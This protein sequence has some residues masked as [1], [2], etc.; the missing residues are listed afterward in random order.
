M[1]SAAALGADRAGIANIDA[2]IL[3]LQ[4]SIEALRMERKT[5]QTRL[6]S[7]T[8][9]V[10]TLP[11]EIVS[12]IFIQFLPVYPLCPRM[13]GLLSPICL[14]QICLEWRELALGTPALWRAVSTHALTHERQLHM[15][16][17]WLS[18]SGCCPLSIKMEGGIYNADSCHQIFA[19]I[20]P[21]CARWEYLKL[22]CTSLSDLLT[23]AGPIPLLRDLDIAVYE[24][25]LVPAAAF[26]QAPRLRAFTDRRQY[27][28]TYPPNFLPWDQLT[29]VT[30]V[31]IKPVECSAILNQTVN[32]VHC[33]LIIWGGA[34][35][36]PDDIQLTSLKSLV[37]MKFDMDVVPAQYLITFI[38]PALRK[39]QVPDEFLLST[40]IGTLESF[41]SKSGCQLQEV[42]ITGERS[43]S[44]GSYRTA[45]P[46]IPNFTFNRTLT[47][48]NVTKKLEEEEPKD[49][50]NEE[51]DDERYRF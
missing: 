47:R 24:G 10:L 3:R 12:E 9:P 35:D 44:R 13:I 25:G 49:S 36:Q 41:I 6:D 18:R 16:Q 19:A 8:Y 14:T 22:S 38:V 23:I 45:F 48:W 5:I 21:H 27:Q 30:L 15:L 31:A 2:E 11:N 28:L 32:L 4:L 1:S 51:S 46:S 40:P 17:S 50:D 7:Y 34:L 26:R 43:V 20:A 29:S 39:L 42:C 33:E 37:L